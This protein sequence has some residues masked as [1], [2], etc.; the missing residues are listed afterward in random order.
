MAVVR[1]RPTKNTGSRDTLIF[2]SALM[3]RT[4]PYRWI[5]YLWSLLEYQM[6]WELFVIVFVHNTHYLNAKHSHKSSYSS[7]NF[8]VIHWRKI[9]MNLMLIFTH[10]RLAWDWRIYCLPE[11]TAVT[12]PVPTPRARS[13][14]RR[15]TM[16]L[17]LLW[18]TK[19][20]GRGWDTWIV[21]RL[22]FYIGKS[23]IIIGT[24]L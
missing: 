21:Y 3:E 12:S 10:L 7:Q 20:L 8:L 16:K 22:L 1:L 9:R 17:L 13:S 6:V 4:R 2:P 24:L 23:C 19:Y 14:S 11:F 18:L 5:K 15:I